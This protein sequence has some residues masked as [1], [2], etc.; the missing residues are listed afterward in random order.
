MTVTSQRHSVLL[1]NVFTL[2][3][4][5]VDAQ[6]KSL[7]QQFGRLLYK[8]ISSDDLENRNDSDLYGATLSLWNGL[9]TF[10]DASP[11]IRVFNPEIAK[12]GW[13]SSHTIV[14]I[15]VRDMP[16]LVDSVRMCLN[17]LNITAHLFL[18]SPIG[19]KRNDKKHIAEFSDMDKKVDGA[20]KETVIFVEVDHQTTKKDIDTLTKEL[21]SVV[22]EVS[23]AVEDWQ[24]MTNT[25]KDVIKNKDAFNW[26]VSAEEDKQIKGF[27][28]WLADH[29]FT[30]MGYRYYE[31]KA[32][33]GDHR[34]IPDNDTSLGLMKNSV[35]SRERLLSKLPSSA[36]Q[37]SLSATPLILTKTNSRARDS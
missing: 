17:R 27:L 31:V 25:L 6:Q 36:R 35:N 26:P 8:N 16:F 9:A 21:H 7:V 12:H 23:L 4:K 1:D 33:E 14:E 20:K 29:N 28:E 22:D 37:E 15:I 10:D 18:H 5:K 24:G 32:I 2:I 34:W 3:D 30:M 19:I 11:Y 13:H